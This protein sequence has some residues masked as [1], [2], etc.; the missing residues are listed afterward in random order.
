MSGS[1][2]FE[3]MKAMLLCVDGDLGEI[4]EKQRFANARCFDE[5]RKINGKKG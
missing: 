1:L 3:K 5:Q 2:F 4:L